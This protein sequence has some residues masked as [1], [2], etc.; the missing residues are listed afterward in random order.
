ML[1]I[2]S[3][4]ARGLLWAIVEDPLD[5]VPRLLLADVLEE[6]WEGER[7]SFIRVQCELAHMAAPWCKADARE[8]NC[9]ELGLSP[10]C[11]WCAL[12]RRERELL[13]AHAEE[14]MLAT[15][16]D[17]GDRMGCLLLNNLTSATIRERQGCPFRRGFVTEITCTLGDWRGAKCPCYW[18]EQNTNGTCSRCHGTGRTIGHGPAL[19]LAAPI[20]EVRLVEWRGDSC[21]QCASG[22]VPTDRDDN[23]CETCGGL[24]NSR[25]AL[26]WARQEAGLPALTRQTG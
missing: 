25:A 10:L 8:N 7:A 3:P 19:V 2:T 4:A 26:A 20:E 18:T 22:V 21:R 13:D 9:E 6:T 23:T 1:Q 11:D 17:V 12:R 16:P 5:D 14:W 24:H 15:F